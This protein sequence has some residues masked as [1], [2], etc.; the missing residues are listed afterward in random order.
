MKTRL[1]PRRISSEITGN[2]R[3]WNK[4]SE[5]FKT[6][7]TMCVNTLLMR[8]RPTP[9]QMPSTRWL[10]KARPTR[11]RVST[12]L[13]VKAR[14]TPR[15]MSRRR[16]RPTPLWCE[17]HGWWTQHFLDGECHYGSCSSQ[18][19]SSSVSILWLLATRPSTMSGT[20]WPMK[21][22]H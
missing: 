14:P 3:T 15:P 19:N 1:T 21:T 18:I 8:S 4:G 10:T 16:S 17:P 2:K 11:R 7:S 6:Y 20:H 5:K 13:L 12:R 9:R 22:R